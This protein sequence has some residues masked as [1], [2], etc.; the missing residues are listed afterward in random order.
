VEGLWRL[1]LPFVCFAC[2]PCNTKKEGVLLAEIALQCF[3]TQVS[4]TTFVMIYLAKNFT[5]F[6]S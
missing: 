6:T 4:Y 2:L 3:I 5:P 1:P